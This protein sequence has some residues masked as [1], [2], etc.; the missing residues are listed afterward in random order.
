MEGGTKRWMD[1]GVDGRM[2]GRTDGERR[3]TN[4]WMGRVSDGR[5]GGWMDIQ[6]AT[7]HTTHPT[8]TTQTTHTTRYK[9]KE[10]HDNNKKD[11][12]YKNKK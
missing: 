2:E 4:G 12:N 8:R 5:T 10:Q 7:T 9:P 3:L 11:S 6:T 1:R